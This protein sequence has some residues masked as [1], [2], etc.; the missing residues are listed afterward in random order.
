[1]GFVEA[2]GSGAARLTFRGRSMRSFDRCGRSRHS[3]LF[4]GDCV[5]Y[6]VF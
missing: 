5:V 1:M 4:D 3:G 6:L 2:P